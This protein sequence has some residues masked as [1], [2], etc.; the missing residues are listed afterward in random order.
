[1]YMHFNSI[2]HVF[3][4]AYNTELRPSAIAASL[5]FRH[6][7]NVLRDEAKSM[8]GPADYSITDRQLCAC[9]NVKGYTMGQRSPQ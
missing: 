1:M 7:S 3:H 4:E 6:A 8:P 2:D 9:K 5:K